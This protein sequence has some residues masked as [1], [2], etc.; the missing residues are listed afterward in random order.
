[1]LIFFKD[2]QI[3]IDDVQLKKILRPTSEDINFMSCIIKSIEENSDSL[4]PVDIFDESQHVFYEG[5]DEWIRCHFKN[6]L[7]HMLRCSSLD[8]I[9]LFK[10]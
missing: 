7:L 10:I 5:S 8:G 2:N 6:Y 9:F 4:K 3:E 1:M